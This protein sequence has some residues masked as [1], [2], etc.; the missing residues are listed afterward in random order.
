[1]A[2]T[3]KRAEQ[4]NQQEGLTDERLDLE[5]SEAQRRTILKYTDLPAHLAKPLSAQGVEERATQFTLDE[6]DELLDRLERAVYRAKGNEKQK[7][8]RIV[9]KVAGLLGSEVIP[10]H[11]ASHR[12]SKKAATIFQI[13]MTLKGIDPPIWRRIHTADCTLE[14]V[15]EIIQVTMG[16]EFEHLYRFTIGGVDYADLEMTSDEEVEDACATRLS[17]VL[18][19]EN[20]RPRFAYEYDFGDEWIHQLIVEERF[21]PKEGVKYPICVGG[22]RACPPEDCGGPWA[23]ADFVEAIGDPDHRRHEELLEWVGG[24]FD[25]ERF[26]QEAV[27]T[28]LRRLRTRRA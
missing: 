18:P 11:V 17:A 8:L 24:E 7:V 14:E 10:S 9:Q 20:R 26:D 27:N 21:L 12:T 15:H 4:R 1:M 2:R 23:Y 6:L 5:L 3:N 19:A 22:Q 28:E 25:P 16:W 13:K